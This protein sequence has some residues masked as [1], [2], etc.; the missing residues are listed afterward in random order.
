MSAF[1]CGLDLEHEP[2]EHPQGHCDGKAMVTP[3]REPGGPVTDLYVVSGLEIPWN[4][5]SL[6]LPQAR[7]LRDLLDTFVHHHYNP[8][9]AVKVGELIPACWP[10]HPGLAHELPAFYAQ[11]V[12]VHQSGLADAEKAMHWHDRWLP[13]FRT[14]LPGWL[15]SSDA[16]RCNPTVGHRANWNEA[17]D[18]VADAAKPRGVDGFDDAVENA[19]LGYTRSP[20]QLT[21]D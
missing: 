9:Y 15:G 4:W 6:T 7:E 21:K 14:R 16:V 12:Y 3:D 1:R 11:W 18:K 10:L 17:A 19:L 5:A 13:G 20:A 8:V 2:H